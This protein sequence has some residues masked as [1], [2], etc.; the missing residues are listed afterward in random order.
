MEHGFRRYGSA[1]KLS[2]DRSWTRPRS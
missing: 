1:S 2:P